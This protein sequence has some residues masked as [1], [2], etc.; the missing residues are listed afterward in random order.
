MDLGVLGRMQPHLHLRWGSGFAKPSLTTTNTPEK[1]LK[2]QENRSSPKRPKTHKR[3]LRG[4]KEYKA[5]LI[6]FWER[7]KHWINRR[8]SGLEKLEPATE[9]M[10]TKRQNGASLEI[11]KVRMKRMT[12]PTHW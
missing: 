1:P 8:R 12:L 11:V 9:E 5:Y 2:I 10:K 4:G 7:G 6:G 3:L